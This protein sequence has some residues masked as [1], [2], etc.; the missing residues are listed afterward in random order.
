M[1]ES[2]QISAGKQRFSILEC[3]LKAAEHRRT[4]K[5]FLQNRIAAAALCKR[6]VVTDLG[7]RKSTD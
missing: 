5:H 4:P 7:V 3:S 2:D 6:S 1:D